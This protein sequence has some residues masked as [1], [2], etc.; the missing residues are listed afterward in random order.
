VRLYLS[1]GYAPQFDLD[2]DPE[3]YSQ[4]PFDGRLRFTKTLVR[5]AFSKSA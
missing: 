1:Q 4:P 3:E 2:R 5:E